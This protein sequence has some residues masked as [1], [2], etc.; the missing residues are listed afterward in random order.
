MGHHTRGGRVGPP[1]SGTTTSGAGSVLRGWAGRRLQL[2]TGPARLCSLPGPPSSLHVC[3]PEMP[4]H[5]SSHLSW[6]LPPGTPYLRRSTGHLRPPLSLCLRW[7]GQQKP[8]TAPPTLKRTKTFN[9]SSSLLFSVAFTFSLHYLLSFCLR[10]TAELTMAHTVRLGRR[11]ACPKRRGTGA[12]R[13]YVSRVWK[14]THGSLP[15][16]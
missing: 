2:S 5:V 13:N 15:F 1:A 3:T 11:E 12:K 14:C 7:Q 16:V 10:S 6:A 9:Q 4:P 8:P